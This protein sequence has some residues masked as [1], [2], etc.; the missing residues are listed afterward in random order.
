MVRT[1]IQLFTLKDVDEPVWR[2]IDRVGESTFDGVELYGANVDDLDDA[3]LERAKMALDEADLSVAGCHFRAEEIE[4]EF[5]DIVHVCDA[6]EIPNL[7]VPTYDGDAFSSVDGIEAAADRLGTIAA[8]LAEHDVD[9]LYHNHTFEFDEVETDDGSQVAF[10]AFVDRA[11]GRF[12]FE[13]DV[14]LA[15]RA[16]YD[17]IDLLEYTAGQAPLVH[18]TDTVPE[19]DYLLHADV[20]EG[21][22]DLDA[23]VRAAGDTGAEWLV[24]ENGRTDDGLASLKHG[25]ETF[26]DFRARLESSPR[27][28]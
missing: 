2:L 21:A 8:D 27:S 23:C 20:G 15:S 19:D 14:G 11:D 17:P 5:D 4:D 24:C 6:L 18:L 12:G 7:V 1:A 28:R 16:G 10:E 3:D 13:P 22:V 25:S 9:L 26:A